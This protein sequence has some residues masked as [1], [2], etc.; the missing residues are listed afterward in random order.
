MIEPESLRP[1]CAHCAA[2]CCTALSFSRSAEFAFDKP[3]GVPCRNLRADFSCGIHATLRRDGMKGCTSFDCFGAGQKVTQLTFGG[4]Q[5]WRGDPTRAPAMFRVFR[6]MLDLHEILWYLALA[7]QT[8]QASALWPEIDEVA[9]WIEEV[10]RQPSETL[11]SLDTLWMNSQIT[12][13]LDAVS[14]LVRADGAPE[15]GASAGQDLSG[16][17]LTGADLRGTGLAGARLRGTTLTAADLRGVD[18]SRADL[19]GADLRGARLDDAD[20]SDALFA[21]QMQL[22]SANG[23]PQTRLPRSLLRP[24]HWG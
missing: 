17:D 2:W 19:L 14:D 4:Q 10:T 8:P 15:H 22:N 18:L 24:G 5:N 11:E 6:A 23:N 12:P 3:V 16:Q 9:E 13:L 1:N 20:L 7:R 21:T